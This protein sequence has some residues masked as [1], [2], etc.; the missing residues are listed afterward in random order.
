MRLIFAL[1]AVLPLLAQERPQ[2]AY[3][4]TSSQTPSSSY[5]TRLYGTASSGAQSG[6]PL[7]PAMAAKVTLG[8]KLFFDKRMS[9]D[10][11]VACASCHIPAHGFADGRVRSPGVFSREGK[12]HSPSLIGRGFG[13]SQ[14]WDGRAATLEEQVVE[15]IK[16]PAEMGTTVEGAVSRLR[17]DKAYSDLTEDSLTQSLASYVRTIRSVDSPFDRFL[18]GA[19]AGLSDLEREGLRLFRDSARCYIC[20]SGDNLTDEMFHN[21]GVAWRDGRIQDE[22][23]AGITGNAIH[24][25]AFKTPTLRDVARRGPYMH[26]GSISSL[27]EV[28]DLYDRG[29]IDR[30]SRDNDIHP[31]NLQ[32]GEKADLIVF[33]NTL[34]SAP[35]PYPVPV[36]PR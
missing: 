17:F 6:Q 14:F 31:L 18:S 35:R 20:H 15:P 19:P 36:L 7:D 26:D 30:P 28:I 22:G 3:P 4:Q 34:S 12:R 27:A 33:L 11:Q 23:R 24:R 13:T 29:G 9:A 5:G 25:G 1:A 8:K 2:S 21:T 16:N 10:G 32:N